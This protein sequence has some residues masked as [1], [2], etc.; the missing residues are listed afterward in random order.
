MAACQLTSGQT[1]DAICSLCSSIIKAGQHTLRC[2]DCGISIHLNC[3]YKA[4]KDAGNDAP[5]NKPDWLHEFILHSALAHRC[6]DCS[7]KFATAPREQCKADV[8][9]ET[10]A[11]AV[12]EAK[13]QSLHN[14]ITKLIS[15]ED[16]ITATGDKSVPPRYP[17]TY[18]QAA[19]STAAVKSAVSEAIQEQQKAASDKSS[20]VVFGFPDEGDDYKHLR[21]MLDF[22]DCRC[23]ITHHS[24]VGF[25]NNRVRPIR[26]ELKS[27]NDAKLVLARA[28]HLRADEY[29]AGVFINKW[30][31][32]TEMKLVREKRR[33]CD[34]LSKDYPSS[35]HGRKPFVV[36][37]G[38]IMQRLSNGRLQAYHPRKNSGND[39]TQA[40]KPSSQGNSTLS[41]QT[42]NT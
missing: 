1:A 40:A 25:A 23:I 33:E 30:L 26:L 36:V 39:V 24:R 22:L 12:L 42:K 10:A 38:T 27:A 6:K 11:I 31:S 35:H 20:V 19:V 8:S 3:M 9:K 37:S 28:K 18:A 5:K 7:E 13:I 14:A 2:A 29:Y 4:F 15:S 41:S 17:L 16:A 21:E 32:E 34:N